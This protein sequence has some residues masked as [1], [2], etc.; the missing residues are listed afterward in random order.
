[1]YWLVD[2]AARMVW[3]HREP[4]EGVYRVAEEHSEDGSLLLPESNVSWPVRSMLAPESRP[5]GT[6]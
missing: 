3:V 5:L 1:M 2:L 4:E 6:M